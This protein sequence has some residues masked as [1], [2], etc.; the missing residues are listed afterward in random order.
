ML[1][2][3]AAGAESGDDPMAKKK[4]CDDNAAAWFTKN[5]PDGKASTYNSQ[6]TATYASHYHTIREKCFMLVAVNQVSYYA[7]GTMHTVTKQL[8]DLD[9]KGAYATFMETNSR[10]DVCIIEGRNC[11]SQGQWDLLIRALYFEDESAKQEALK[12]KK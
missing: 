8:I 3:S 12:Q 2:R 4:T 9:A 6:S 7:Q 11:K 5:F 10:Q 1:V